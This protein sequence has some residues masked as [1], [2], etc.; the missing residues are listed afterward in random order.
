MSS[1]AKKM[2]EQ[3][4]EIQ[5]QS[6]QTV[7][8]RK[9]KISFGEVMLL[10]ILAAAIAFMSVKVVSNQA[11]IYHTDKE[12]QLAQASIEEQTKINNDL[13]ITVDELSTYERIWQ[14]AEEMGFT[15]NEKNVKGVQE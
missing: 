6:V 8:I 7:V 12:I 11:A 1:S 3:Q 9:A 5:Q 2:Q 15:L 14:K 10:C 4:Q 13:K